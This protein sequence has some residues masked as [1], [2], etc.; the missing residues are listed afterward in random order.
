MWEKLLTTLI[1]MDEFGLTNVLTFWI[2]TLESQSAFLWW[3]PLCRKAMSMSCQIVFLLEVFD[4]SIKDML[5]HLIYVI[6]VL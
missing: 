3:T 1:V 6:Y 4:D 2:T 5:I